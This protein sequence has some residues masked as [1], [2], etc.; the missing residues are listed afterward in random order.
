[1]VNI[2]LGSLHE[3]PVAVIKY[4]PTNIKTENLEQKVSIR[5]TANQL[6]NMSV[7][8]ERML[9]QKKKLQLELANARMVAREARE[10]LNVGHNIVW[11]RILDIEC[12]KI[13]ELKGLTKDGLA[14]APK[15]TECIRQA[16]VEKKQRPRVQALTHFPRNKLIQKK[17]T[18]VKE[19]DRVKYLATSQL[20]EPSRIPFSPVYKSKRRSGYAPRSPPAKNDTK[21]IPQ[22]PLPTL[23]LSTIKEHHSSHEATDTTERKNKPKKPQGKP[24]PRLHE[25]EGAALQGFFANILG[26]SYTTCSLVQDNVKP[27]LFDYD[28]RTLASD[29]DSVSS[30]NSGWTWGSST[31]SSTNTADM[32]AVRQLAVR[33]EAG[34]AQQGKA[35]T[36][37]KRQKSFDD[38]D[39]DD[40]DAS[41]GPPIET[42]LL[43]NSKC[44][45]NH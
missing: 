38:D 30:S 29:G 25:P 3:V 17:P 6:P 8:I 22:T 11:S 28:L 9:L 13:S 26:K 45:S 12:L 39:D 42:V 24:T 31:K 36:K 5:A 32:G 16:A 35:P 44:R 7:T 27:T 1:L 2:S 14:A 21:A 33:F 41:T 19:K 23:T 10:N 4:D 15:R 34:R 18:A 37:P 43:Q 40:D 20:K